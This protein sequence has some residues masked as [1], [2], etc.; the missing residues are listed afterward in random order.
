MH[1]ILKAANKRYI[2]AYYAYKQNPNRRT[3]RE[4]NAARND[5][6]K[7]EMLF[8]AAKRQIKASILAE[9]KR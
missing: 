7:L 9:D 3:K 8:C 1:R 5:W 6:Y 2:K 4:Y